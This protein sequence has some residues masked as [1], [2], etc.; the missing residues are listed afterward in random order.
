MSEPKLNYFV[1]RRDFM[2]RS[3]LGHVIT[4]E[5]GKPAHVPKALHSLALEKGLLPCDKDGKELDLEAASAV[6]PEE[7]KVL[8]APE[9]A[10]EREE[11]VLKILKLLVERNNSADFGGGGIPKPEAVSQALGWRVDTKEVRTVWNKHRQALLVKE[12]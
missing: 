7:V 8:V 10:E 3:T 4:F 12:K 9:D 6:A 1:S 11:A 5:K 2:L